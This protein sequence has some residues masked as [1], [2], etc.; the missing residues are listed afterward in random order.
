MNVPALVTTSSMNAGGTNRIWSQ[1]PPRIT[2][3]QL[4]NRTRGNFTAL[5][6]VTPNYRSPN[7]EQPR[8]TLP[9][10]SLSALILQAIGP[11]SAWHA[12]PGSIIPRS[13][14]IPGLLLDV[15]MQWLTKQR[16]GPCMRGAS[17]VDRRHI[18]SFSTSHIL[19]RSS[20]YFQLD[21]N[22]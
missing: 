4:W 3:T 15:T 2:P 18:R 20:K 12:S 1:K 22:L 13:G 10:V 9:V 16:K 11:R 7:R 19:I 21:I 8:P 5:Y 6:S 17:M 14:A